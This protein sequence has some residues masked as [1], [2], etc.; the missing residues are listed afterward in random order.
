MREDILQRAEQYLIRRRNRMRMLRAFTAM[1]LVV[2][3]TTSYVL[4]LPGLTMQAPAY[5]G[6]EEH[7]HDADCYN[8]E[9]IC[10]LEERAPTETRVEILDCSFKPHVHDDDCYTEDGK[11][12]CGISTKY[13]HRHT[14]ECRNDAGDLICG[15]V[16]NPKHRHTSDCYANVS[17]LTCTT[18]ESVGH[19]HEQGCYER[20]DSNGP[21]CG[22][23]A[24]PGHMHTA[25]CN[26]VIRELNCPYDIASSTNLFGHSSH[27]DE[28]YTVHVELGCGLEQGDGAH[29]HVADCFPFSEEPTCGL[30]SGEGGHTHAGAC[31]TVTEELECDELADL[32]YH[33]SDCYDSK[34]GFVICGKQEMKEHNHSSGCVRIVTAVDEGHQHSDACYERHYTCTIP[35]HKHT[36]ECYV[37]PSTEPTVS[38]APVETEEVSTT[39]TVVPAATEAPTAAPE[40]T[41]APTPTAEVTPV[42]AA[43]AEPTESPGVTEAVSTTYT[44]VPE[45]TEEPT[46]APEVT[47]EPTVEPEVTE[48]PTAEPEVTEEPTAAPEVTEEPTVEPEVTEEPT[49]A[50]EVTEEPTAEPEVTEEPTAEPEV[51]EEPTAEPEVT[52]EPTAEPEVTEEPTVE[53]EVTE[54]P[55]AAPEVT[56]EPT[57]EPEVTEEPTVE[58]EVTEEPTVEPEVT[59]EP[60]VEPE[61]TEE[62]TVEPEVTEEPTAAPELT[63]EPTV[64]PEVTE[65]PTVAPEATMEPTAAPDD[66]GWN[67][68]EYHQLD[69]YIA[70]TFYC[71]LTE[72]SHSADCEDENGALICGYETEH[73]HDA[74]CTVKS[75]SYKC[76]KKAHTH[77][78]ACTNEDSIFGCGR[79]E[80]VHS[81]DCLYVCGQAQHTHSDGCY[82]EA[83]ELIC[84][85]EEHTHAASCTMRSLSKESAEDITS[86]RADFSTYIADS[87]WNTSDGVDISQGSDVVYNPETDSFETK[88]EISF[89]IPNYVLRGYSYWNGWYWVRV[90][91]QQEFYYEIP[92]EI[93]IADSMIDKPFPITSPDGATI[94]GTFYIKKADDG[95]YYLQIE[96][97]DEYVR[98]ANAGYSMPGWPVA[99]TPY[100][101]GNISFGCEIDSDAAQDDG[102]IR[103]E[104]T[105]EDVL[106]IPPEE[107]EYP[108]NETATA[109]IATEK[110]GSYVREGNKLYYTVKVHSDKGTPSH[111]K[112]EDKLVFNGITMESF[113]T[114]VVKGYTSTWNGSSWVSDGNEQSYSVVKGGP[115]EATGT[116]ATMNDPKQGPAGDIKLDMHLPQITDPGD[117]KRFTYEITYE[118]NLEDVG[119]EFNGNGTNTVV[120]KSETSPENK[121]EASAS[122]NVGIYVDSLAKVG[123]YDQQTDKIKWSITVNGSYQDIAGAVLTDEM[124]TTITE[125]DAPSNIVV[126]DA[127]GN[128]LSDGNGYQ[129]NYENG[130]VSSI[131][132]FGTATEDGVEVNRN[133]YIIEYYTTPTQTSSEYTETNNVTLEKDGDE[134]KETG[135]AYVKRDLRIYKQNTGAT[136]DGTDRI[137]DWKS[138][139][140]V[141]DSGLTEDL[142]ITDTISGENHYMSVAQ[143]TTLYNSI[144]GQNWFA[145]GADKT[146][147]VTYKDAD[148]NTQTASAADMVAN[149]GNYADCQITGFTYTIYKDKL[150]ADFNGQT[151]EITYQTT[152]DTAGL[153]GTANYY[154]GWGVGGSSTGANHQYTYTE[155]IKVDKLNSWD[156]NDEPNMTTTTGSIEWH[157]NVTQDKTYQYLTITDTLPPETVLSYLKFGQYGSTT[158]SLENPEFDEDSSTPINLCVSNYDYHEQGVRISGTYTPST[159][160]I[161]LKVTPADGA[162]S[163]ALQ[164]A[165]FGSGQTFKLRVFAELKDEYMPDEEGEKN[166]I[167]RVTNHVNVSTNEGSYGE[168]D[169]SYNITAEGTAKVTKTDGSNNGNDSYVNNQTGELT[170]RVNV[171]QNNTYDYLEIV[172]T[173]PEGVELVN[174]KLGRYTETSATYDAATADTNGD[175][176]L[177]FA[178]GTNDTGV[179]YF[180][181]Y[182][183]NT[184]VVTITVKP[185]G[186]GTSEVYGNGKTFQLIYNCKVEDDLMPDTENGEYKVELGKLTNNVD[187]TTEKG[188]YGSDSQGQTVTVE[189]PKPITDTVGK[190]HNWTPSMNLLEYRVDLNPD[191]DDLDPSKNMLTVTDKLTYYNDP[192]N[193]DREL[194][195]IKSSVKLFYADYDANGNPIKDANGRLVKGVE[196]P[197]SDWTMSYS[198]TIYENSWQQSDCTMVLTVPDE[199]ALI[200]EYDYRVSMKY[201]PGWDNKL[202]INNTVSITGYEEENHGSSD[203]DKWEEYT[204]GGIV[205]TER[206][207][208]IVKYD[209]SNHA[210]LIEGA[211]FTVYEYDGETDT[212]F[213]LANYV[214]DAS[215]N[216]MVQWQQAESDVQYK[217]NTAYKIVETQPA[218]GYVLEPNPTP[219]YFYWANATVSTSSLPDNWASEYNP[220]EL[221][222]NPGHVEVDN[223]RRTT[224]VSVNKIWDVEDESLI[225]DSLT[226]HLKRYAVPVDV[227]EAHPEYNHGLSSDMVS[228]SGDLKSANASNKVPSFSIMCYAGSTVSFDLLINKDWT[229]ENWGQAEPVFNNLPA[230]TT[231]TRTVSGNDVIYHYDMVVNESVDLDGAFEYV[232]GGIWGN[233]WAWDVPE[234]TNVTVTANTGEG[235]LDDSSIAAELDQYR[236]RNYTNTMTL[237]N[238]GNWE[239]LWENLDLVGTDANGNEVHYKYYV[240]EDTPNGFAGTITGGSSDISGEF[241]ITNEYDESRTELTAVKVVKIW[242]DAAGNVID[243]LLDAVEIRLYQ[244]DELTGKEIVYPYKG[245]ATTVINAA[246]DWS[247]YFRDLPYGTWDKDGNVT[248]LYSYRIE[249]VTKDPSFVTQIIAVNA[250]GVEVLD[251]NFNGSTVTV[252]NSE[253]HKVS[254]TVYKEFE[255]TEGHDHSNCEV[256]VR[257]DRY[258]L[259]EDGYILD[260]THTPVTQVLSADNNWSYT[261]EELDD[262]NLDG[263][264]YQYRVTE[265]LVN[266][267]PVAESGYVPVYSTTDGSIPNDGSMTI[268]NE[269]PAEM[270]VTKEWLDI[271]GNPIDAPAGAN[272]TF[273]LWRTTVQQISP[274]T[275]E[276]RAYD[277]TV[278]AGTLVDELVATFTLNAACDWEKIFT[279]LPAESLSGEAYHYYV[280]EIAVEG[281]TT[282]YEGNYTSNEGEIT[283]KNYRDDTEITYIKINKQWTDLNGS[284]IEPDG[285][286]AVYFK[287]YENG[288]DITGNLNEATNGVTP[289]DGYIEVKA[290]AG[291]SVKVDGLNAESTYKIVEYLKQNGTYTEIVSAAYAPQEGPTGTSFNVTNRLTEITVEKVW[292]DVNGNTLTMPNDKEIVLDLYCLKYGSTDPIKLFEVKLPVAQEDGTYLWSRTVEDLT[293]GPADAPV[294]YYFVERVPTGFDVSYSHTGDDGES[295]VLA[296]N[297]GVNSGKVTVTN[298]QQDVSFKLV[299]VWKD[300]S[301]N[302]METAPTGV[303]IA[304]HLMRV[305]TGTDENGSPADEIVS[306][307]YLP[308]MEG[309]WEAEFDK[310]PRTDTDGNA[311]QYYIAEGSSNGMS[312]YV[313]TYEPASTNGTVGTG[314]LTDNNEVTVTN[315]LQQKNIKLNIMKRWS[316]GSTAKDVTINLYRYILTEDG[317]KIVDPTYTNV[318]TFAAD[319]TAPYQTVADLPDYGTFQ[320]DGTTYEGDF[321]YYVEEQNISE[322]YTVTYSNDDGTTTVINP[323]DASLDHDGNLRVIN[324]ERAKLN[325]RKAWNTANRK[326]SISFDLYRKEIPASAIDDGTGETEFVDVTF[327]IVVMNSYTGSDGQTVTEEALLSSVTKTFRKGAQ[328]VWKPTWTTGWTWHP[329]STSQPQSVVYKTASGTS[330]P[331][332]FDTSNDSATSSPYKYTFDAGY[333][334]ENGTV[335]WTTDNWYQNGGADN[336]SWSHSFVVDGIAEA[337]TYSIRAASRAIGDVVKVGSFELNA[338]NGTTQ[339]ATM[340]IGDKTYTY[341]IQDGDWSMLFYDLPVWS[342]DGESAYVY[343]VEEPTEDYLVSYTNNGGIQS[344]DITITN[345]DKETEVAEVTVTK[346]YASGSPTTPAV[347]VELYRSVTDGTNTYIE[348]VGSVTLSAD[349]NWTYKWSDLLRGGTITQEGTPITGDYTYFV[350]EVVPSGFTVTYSTTDGVVG[351]DEVTTDDGK[352]LSGTVNITNTPK[353]GLTVKKVWDGVSGDEIEFAL[354]R[355]ETAVGDESSKEKVSITFQMVIDYEWEEESTGIMYPDRM[356][357]ATHTEEFVKGATVDWKPIW[358]NVNDDWHPTTG[359][360]TY[361]GNPIP[362]KQPVNNVDEYHYTFHLGQVNESGTV[363]WAMDNWF[364]N[365]PDYGF[366]WEHTFNKNAGNT[367][368][369]YTL[370]AGNN[371]QMTFYELPAASTDGLYA[372]DYEVEELTAGYGVHYSYNTKTNETTGEIEGTITITNSEQEPETTFVKAEK[373]YVTTDSTPPEVKVRLYRRITEVQADGDGNQIEVTLEELVPDSEQT[374]N[375]SNNWEYTWSNLLC[376]GEITKDGKTV[377]G[378]YSFRIEEE[379]PEGYEV[380]YSR[381]EGKVPNNGTVVITNKEVTEV[382]VEKKW[383]NQDASTAPEVEF[384]LIQ[385]ATPIEGITSDPNYPTVDVKLQITQ[386]VGGSWTA[387]FHTQRTTVKKEANV[388]WKIHYESKWGYPGSVAWDTQIASTVGYILA[389]DGTKYDVRL[390]STGWSNNK[391]TAEYEVT[392]PASESG[393]YYWVTEG[394]YPD[395]D[396][397]GFDANN[398]PEAYWRTTSLTA[399]DPSLG[400]KTKTYGT[401]TLNNAN[402][403][404]ETIG[405]LPTKDTDGIY[406]YSYYVEETPVDGY[407]VQYS[408]NGGIVGG[409]ITITNTRPLITIGVVKQYA[410]GSSTT[411]AVN[412]DLVRSITQNGTTLE[413]VVNTQNLSDANGWRYTWGDL[414][415]SGSITVDG[416]TVAGE[417]TYYVREKAPLGFSVTY[418]PNEDGSVAANGTVTITNT[419]QSQLKVEKVWGDGA[420]EQEIQFKLWR[421]RVE[422]TNFVKCPSCG[423]DV[424]YATAHAAKCGTEGHYTCD[425]DTHTVCT[426]CNNGYV[427]A[428]G[429]GD[430]VCTTP[431]CTNC[432]EEVSSST[433]HVAACGTIGHYTCDGGD[434]SAADCGTSGHYKCDGSNHSQMNCGHYQCAGGNNHTWCSLCNQWSCNGS[435]HGDGVCNGG[436]TTITCPQCSATVNSVTEHECGNC[437]GYTCQGEHGYGK[438]YPIC[439]VCGKVES[440]AGAHRNGIQCGHTDHCF[441]DG[442]THTDC[443]YCDSGYACEDGHGDGEC[444]ATRCATCGEKVDSADEHKA[445][446]GHFTCASDYNAAD[447]ATC[448]VCGKYLCNGK[449]H[450]SGSCD[451]V[452]DGLTIDFV[453]KNTYNN[454]TDEFTY[455]LE[456][457]PEGATVTWKVYVTDYSNK[458]W[459]PAWNPQF[460]YAGGTYTANPVYDNTAGYCEYTATFTATASEKI[461]LVIGSNWQAATVTQSAEYVEAASLSLSSTTRTSRTLTRTP[462]A[463][464]VVDTTGATDMGTYVLNEGNSWEHIFYELPQYSSD[465]KYM[466]TYFVQE[467]TDG[468]DV[469]YTNNAGVVDGTITITNEKHVPTTVDVPVTK[470]WVDENGNAYAVAEEAIRYFKLFNG[471]ADITANVTSQSITGATLDGEYIKLV[472]P[473]GKSSASFTIVKLPIGGTYTLK[474]YMLVDGVYTEVKDYTSVTANNAITVTNKLTDITVY[475][476]WAPMSNG[477]NA[478][479]RPDVTFELWRTYTGGTDE[480]VDTKVMK[481]PSTALTWSMLPLTVDGTTPYQYYVKEQLPSGFIAG[482]DGSVNVAHGSAGTITNTPTELTVEKA[483]QTLDGTA[484]TKTTGTIYYNLMRQKVTVSAGVETPEGEAEVYNTTPLTLTGDTNWARTHTL[485]PL[486]WKDTVTG[487]SGEYRYYVVETDADGNEVYAQYSDN[488]VDVSTAQTITITNTE[489]AITVRKLWSING[490]A[491]PETLPAIE[492]ELRYTYTQGAM[493]DSD[494]TVETV[495]LT[496][497]TEG[498]NV[499]QDGAG[500]VYWTYTWDELPTHDLVDGEGKVRYY[501]VVESSEPEGFRHT[502]TDLNNFGTTGNTADNPIQIT[503]E[504]IAY[505]LPETGGAGTTPYTVGGLM[506]MMF[507]LTALLY[508][509]LQRKKQW[510]EGREN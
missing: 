255:S 410:E 177:T 39:N 61:V 319:D 336:G 391:N 57:V 440:Y 19:V 256:T 75:S 52:E 377:A 394:W 302:I 145:T 500:N 245:F 169:H 18:E 306:T 93:K 318:L 138:G 185:S 236:D 299:K 6:H 149:P 127:S 461:T 294:K 382:G 270:T 172:D 277:P 358:T 341:E 160:V 367:L 343:Y 68:N 95:S 80:H 204:A 65:E 305:G 223:L 416:V 477:S 77:T 42:P 230:G 107:I 137:I 392:F 491:L 417:Y 241:E 71:G 283:V 279:N 275:A 498:V 54:E 324:H 412:V 337:S 287:L 146:M 430:G 109:N 381:E 215:G 264:A 334:V 7:T 92:D 486:Y 25:E 421:R 207:F 40:V 474:E 492:L 371:W 209:T 131:E 220:R 372:Y 129:I 464:E 8:E 115:A 237:T 124:F 467:I 199:R 347:D 105:T 396:Q 212:W 398:N 218:L 59:E 481:A 106:E 406:T 134:V 189:K 427:C 181:T 217:E 312:D 274:L 484:I 62:P 395:N 315:Q 414:A 506:L 342:E 325:V 385:K 503:N 136:N 399:S 499:T 125:A 357:L 219:H 232:Y 171:I 63:E 459:G 407:A 505:E 36:A 470:L 454:N 187:V 211:V 31:Y 101:Q 460:T 152:A 453:V 158:I 426:Y 400:V 1:A 383:V 307:I 49:A 3:I 387:D 186:S 111:V 457:V 89:A 425:G 423:A 413:E 166:N 82:N 98:T 128:V 468:Y 465:G 428:D 240:I 213:A 45:M 22:L 495:I 72:H 290:D 361:N 365:D 94:E 273:E 13:F 349:N 112:L 55:T 35:E 487:K 233:D 27:T 259:T 70:K 44:P 193:Y 88:L 86:G 76:G 362:F 353:T 258:I 376:Y 157:V 229:T 510:G 338:G 370:N 450:G 369:T 296:E 291:W 308:T 168:D 397:N 438:C 415:Q 424:A 295:K 155:I 163:G 104:F 508:K 404:K 58:P 445:A 433:A 422:N 332:V 143:L 458:G 198:S 309:T 221:V 102:S 118:I 472:T 235:G 123:S 480:L 329:I 132:F 180:G 455:T 48:E 316:K 37:T 502:G 260:T 194:T 97:S 83:G 475:K 248:M 47:E 490:G 251:D 250:A 447:H 231:M 74:L 261:W 156:G 303:S 5:C 119:L 139:F 84:T 390:V 51:T 60:T 339:T 317:Q 373:K 284:A 335:T 488:S 67:E 53:P 386:T 271:D 50:P 46:A 9:L 360:I 14:A 479:Q 174:V 110:S 436:S 297:E 81:V 120:A 388:T 79:E 326:D 167:G 322:D 320:K 91:G 471:T 497:E 321:Y 43:T 176:E 205:S 32:H 164:R 41:E 356:V 267:V 183:V 244:K 434:H 351:F 437:D 333:M 354:K 252:I 366:T 276:A 496:A 462:R 262:A 493:A 408:N 178:I 304:F 494:P 448:G 148:G 192:D 314:I 85:K 509:E 238:A 20:D 242:Q 435:Q 99:Q 379:V 293:A 352:V 452:P 222:T 182:N 431:T 100:S 161:I 90:P 162:D 473:A 345:S 130:K 313:V 331:I 116:T 466:Y 150:P 451:V 103:I 23:T 463:S 216:L 228:I 374:L 327:R 323:Q 64:E 272:V 348:R 56:E 195:L 200:L 501:Y 280:K 403:W 191:A 201:V 26:I 122:A 429:H 135:G 441:E 402:G 389:P 292:K 173:L 140:T 202:Y 69:Q 66:D 21:V 288:T 393:T 311:Y 206:S 268:T 239:G 234:F 4:M 144:Q 289:V 121:V 113:G 485:L 126:K 286:S 73:V 401:Y 184:R 476:T 378:K 114:P 15:L 380:S 300:K 449:T 344:G 285:Y 12:G 133:K 346:A 188:D 203:N 301:G 33:N 469:S 210:K 2:A 483:W 405:S 154:N 147:T 96:F 368:D 364:W 151:I 11:L 175:C 278:D 247:F 442:K 28:C 38:P 263:E 17:T 489:T 224:E 359:V 190:N 246:T 78:A 281:Y 418:S 340:T 456:G 249:E 208:S 507:S 254:A 24:N 170:W 420:E 165:G 504:L 482:N 363:V 29:V 419:E 439:T 443:P 87:K 153:N 196:V 214:T 225:P 409:D 30:E 197:Y 265:T 16:N 179:E 298:T 117:D 350:Q 269:L 310:L 446:C 108:D 34:T 411:P 226:V 328:V 282:E 243:P 10:T 478:Y 375:D 253:R 227:W 355:T 141:Y 444:N 142:V 432:G 384:N 159:G 257:L 330:T 266:G